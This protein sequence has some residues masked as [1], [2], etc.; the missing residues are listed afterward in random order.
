MKNKKEIQKIVR[1][2]Q[3]EFISCFG[4]LGFPLTDENIE[5]FYI[6]VEKNVTQDNYALVSVGDFKYQ[7]N[8]GVTLFDFIVQP[9]I[10]DFDIISNIEDG[11]F[12]QEPKKVQAMFTIN[13]HY[14]AVN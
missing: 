13:Y 7:K 11:H 14:I 1:N 8:T 12:D 4:D 2:I 9:D 5:K 10:D 6:I 3:K